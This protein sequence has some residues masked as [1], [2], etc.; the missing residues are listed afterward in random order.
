MTKY[1]KYFNQIT[2]VHITNL[3]FEKKGT[4]FILGTGRYRGKM[5]T[6]D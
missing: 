4:N 2:I 1:L 3:V 6:V 5:K